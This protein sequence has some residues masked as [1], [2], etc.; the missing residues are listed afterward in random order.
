MHLCALFL[1]LWFSPSILL[2]QGGKTFADSTNYQA[3]TLCLAC[4][5]S[6]ASNA[7]DSDQSTYAELNVP[8][9]LLGSYLRQNFG[10]ASGGK[11]ND[12]ITIILE[13][14]TGLVD[15]NLLGDMQIG[16]YNGGTFNNDAQTLDGAHLQLLTGSQSI[17]AYSFAASADFTSLSLQV[18]SSIVGLLHNVRIYSVYYESAS[19]G[20]S[21]S[22]ANCSGA[23]TQIPTT[24]DLCLLC[25]VDN[26]TNAADN[27]QASASTLRVDA[28]LL[29]SYAQQVL[30]F[31]TQGKAGDSVTVQFSS[32]VGLL[33]ANLLGNLSFASF[34]NDTYNGDRTSLGGSNLFNNVTL[35]PNT[36]LYIV[37]FKPNADF[38]GIEIRLNGGVAGALSQLQVYY[39]CLSSAPFDKPVPA[40]CTGPTK[41]T[42]L[43]SGL[44]MGCAINNPDNAVDEDIESYSELNSGLA[45]LGSFVE[46]TLYFDKAVNAGDKVNI[47]LGSSANLLDATVL[48]S[49]NV[50]SAQDSLPNND[51]TSITTQNLS[52]LNAGGN[53]VYSFTASNKFNRLTIRVNAGL[54]GALKE[55]R[56]Y[57]ACAIIS[58]KPLTPVDVDGANCLN[59]VSQ[60]SA[61]SPL[62]I[63]CKV[64]N[65]NG[66]IDYDANSFSNLVI[67]AGVL[68]SYAQQVFTFEND[69]C[70]TD[71]VTLLL[72]TPSGAI[73]AGI[74]GGIELSTL[75]YGLENND[76]KTA[77][78][79]NG[80]VINLSGS[81]IYR[82]RYVPGVPFNQVRVR[83]INGV[84]GAAASLRIYGICS[85]ASENPK[86]PINNTYTTCPGSTIT[87]APALPAG[88]FVQY[89]LSDKVTEVQTVN[90]TLVVSNIQRDTMFYAK[91]IN[92]NPGA[93]NNYP[94]IPIQIR[95]SNTY[96]IPVS[97]DVDSSNAKKGVYTFTNAPSGYDYNWNFGDGTTSNAQT[98]VK[99][100]QKAG[101][102]T[103]SLI[104]KDK[105]STCQG[106]S[107]RILT[108]LV[109]SGK[110]NEKPEP[111]HG[112][113]P[114]TGKGSD[115]K[116]IYVP[117]AFTP[118]GDG[119]N[120][121]LMVLARGLE[122]LDFTIYNAL[123][124]IVFH[125]SDPKQSWDGTYRGEVQ[126]IGVYLYVAKAKII[127]NSNEINERGTITII[128]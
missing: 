118:N 116:S 74:L 51:A 49:V 114:Y 14:P 101:V 50:S 42:N 58:N 41:Q 37:G 77:N 43:Q 53:F 13:N 80:N 48:G 44:C 106:L 84:A 121:N 99:T 103:V 28:S 26:P 108:V 73:S 69:G 67:D 32:P 12:R 81:N 119:K 34:Q 57:G 59:A 55:L 115:G 63:N 16:T 29:N 61:T 30:Y 6:N 27:D 117:N 54:V 22:F 112:C 107:A 3:S 125:A 78:T 82:F 102:Y 45:L 68:N 18:N 23:N 35:L 9:G 128:R 127:D 88:I 111:C 122:S 94:L 109:G 65:P 105:N 72:Q 91:K 97:F 120:D 2:A 47:Y 124:E 56:I 15:A 19:T 126:P 93:C 75:S 4:S 96:S 71:T 1:L 24:S 89:F 11:K 40:G 21:T 100:Y 87:I 64:D 79:V 62:C 31:P 85:K 46:Q 104:V 17:F 83:L 110:T 7:A 90:S 95:V 38:N 39:A 113:P 5:I 123:G 60:S 86:L 33:N 20:G 66:A 52:L 10:F 92:S 98:P 76:A 25:G 70:N 36:N 8:A